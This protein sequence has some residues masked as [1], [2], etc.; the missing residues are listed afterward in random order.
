MPKTLRRPLAVLLLAACAATAEAGL[1]SQDTAP[2]PSAAA[3]VAIAAPA[4]TGP[5]G[6]SCAAC[7]GGG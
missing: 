5:Q 3:A 6:G 7:W 4:T 1:R 2:H